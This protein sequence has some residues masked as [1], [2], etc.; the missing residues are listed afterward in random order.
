MSVDQRYVAAL[1]AM[2]AAEGTGDAALIAEAERVLHAAGSAWW[3]E[4]WRAAT[5]DLVE[6]SP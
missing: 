4:V 2:V 3:A 6:V 1:R 5:A